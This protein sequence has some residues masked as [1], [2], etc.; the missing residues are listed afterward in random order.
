MDTTTIPVNRF[1]IMVATF[2]NR[3]VI[4]FHCYVTLQISRISSLPN[5]GMTLYQS[6]H[7][8]FANTVVSIVPFQCLTG[9][10]SEG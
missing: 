5:I 3:K 9:I 7:I 8:Y 4:Y 1:Y 10:P 2:Y 6:H